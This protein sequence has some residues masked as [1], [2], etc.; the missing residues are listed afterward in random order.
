[1]TT[2]T[3]TTDV[4]TERR[5]TGDH[6]ITDTARHVADSVAGAAGDVTARIPEVAQ[7]TRDALTEANRMV[8]GGSDSTLT[9]VGAG[10]IGFA[11]GLLVGGA[12]RILVVLSLVPAAL[13]AAT[14]LE[15]VDAEAGHS[16]GSIR[17]QER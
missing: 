5:P 4:K 10:A 16:S 7:G 9:L 17:L 6:G 14:L 11:V 2:T 3:P 1:M 15:R 8:R 13:I 12:N